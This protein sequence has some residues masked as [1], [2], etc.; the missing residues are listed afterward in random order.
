MFLSIINFNKNN[1]RFLRFY[2]TVTSFSG[3][4]LGA[5]TSFLL[6]YY[7]NKK[8]DRENKSFGLMIILNLIV[9]VLELFI[10]FDI[11]NEYYLNHF[12]NLI[13]PL[14]IYL[15]STFLFFIKLYYYGSDFGPLS[16]IYFFLNSIYLV[17]VMFVFHLYVTKEK[18]FASQIFGKDLI[19]KWLKDFDKNMYVFID[20]IN[21][22]F[23]SN[24]L[25][26]LIVF[27]V[28]FVFASISN[29]VFHYPFGQIW[30]YYTDFI[31]SVILLLTHFI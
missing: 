19:Y 5:I 29:I 26:S 24:F 22:F 7:G 14:I 16:L 3:I 2:S 1:L 13:G 4:L 25:Y 11:K 15:Q 31:P 12:A 18:S 9:Q 27:I 23:K 8:Y 28:L 17:L 30:S 20:T 6:M 10:W 21:I